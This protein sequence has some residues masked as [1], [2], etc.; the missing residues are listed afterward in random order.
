MNMSNES[1]SDDL[2]KICKEYKFSEND[3]DKLRQLIYLNHGYLTSFQ[4]RATFDMAWS[5]CFRL[6]DELIA[7]NLATLAPKGR[8]GYALPDQ[9][10]SNSWINKS[11]GTYHDKKLKKDNSKWVMPPNSLLYQRIYRADAGDVEGNAKI[12]QETLDSFNI[13]CEMIGANIGPSVTQYTVKPRK[14]TDI[15]K[16]VELENNIALDLAVTSIRIEA[17]ISGSDLVGIEIPN[18]KPAIVQLSKIFDSNEWQELNSLLPIAIGRGIDGEP[19]IFDLA[20]SPNI[21][22]SGQTGSGKSIM[23]NSILTSLLFCNTPDILKLILIDFKQ[24][25]LA[26]YDDIPH[27][28]TPVIV[29]P[30]KAM[31]ALMWAETEVDRRLKLFKSSKFKNISDHN[32][33]NIGKELPYILIVLDEVSDLMM[34]AGKEAEEVIN[35]ITKSSKE[36]GFCMIIA[37]SRPSTDVLTEKLKT[38]MP[39]RIAFAAASSIDSKTVIDQTGAE[40]LLGKGD[41]LFKRDVNDTVLQRIQGSHIGD[42]DVA[43]LTDY[44]RIQRPPY[45]D[46]IVTSNTVKLSG[47]G[48]IEPTEINIDNQEYKKAVSLILEAGKA[49]TSLLQ[50]K[51]RIGYGKAA[52]FIQMMEDEGIVGPSDGSNPRAIYITGPIN[53]KRKILFIED[54]K[55]LAKVYSTAFEEEGYEVKTCYDGETALQKVLKFDP[56][57]VITG[58]LMPKVSGFDVIDILKNTPETKRIPIIVLSALKLHSDKMRAKKLGALDY[59]VKSEVVIADVKKIIKRHM[60]EIYGTEHSNDKNTD[61]YN[62]NY[63]EDESIVRAVEIVI[64]AK[65][66]STALL[67]RKM[68]IGYGKAARLIEILEERGYVS[69]SDGSRPREVLIDSIDQM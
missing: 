57:M 45:Y 10:K 18:I 33:R 61:E 7:N 49:S 58:I 3:C 55:A 42:D 66:A 46:D 54:D 29:D 59:I 38:F 6:L 65:K 31:S 60:D 56:D 25:E 9:I 39:T 26:T 52:R 68:S 16:I 11:I 30:E 62:V 27:L 51:L 1:N 2:E 28:L 23:L 41:F 17:P 36:A 53:T 20:V 67:Q 34:M 44:L 43:K 64:E 8:P 35:K 63:K 24:V 19:V 14:E 48:G 15:S 13:D 5:I 50:R 47:T 12:I 69:P 40:K 32:K 4:L 22:I 37:T 21:I